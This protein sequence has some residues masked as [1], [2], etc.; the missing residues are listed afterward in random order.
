MEKQKKK[1][2]NYDTIQNSISAFLL[3]AYCARI[4][5]LFLLHHIFFCFVIVFIIW[6]V[7]NFIHCFFFYK[8][9]QHILNLASIRNRIQ[10]T[11]FTSI[12]ILKSLLREAI[13][14][15]SYGI[16][17]YSSTAIIIIIIVVC[18]WI[19]EPPTTII[20]K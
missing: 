1:H 12:L 13:K 4:V 16:L 10:N 11:L 5:N 17:V 19:C 3:H 18:R 15:S 7:D 2:Q 9:K 14:Q 20:R 8:K 6:C